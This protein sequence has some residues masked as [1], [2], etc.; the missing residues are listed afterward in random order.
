[1][2]DDLRYRYFLVTGVQKARARLLLDTCEF[3]HENKRLTALRSCIVIKL[4]DIMSLEL[5]YGFCRFI[6]L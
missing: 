3:C 2:V 5:C 1:M 6:A 4:L